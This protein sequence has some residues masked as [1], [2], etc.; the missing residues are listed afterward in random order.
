MEGLSEATVDGIC[1]LC[2]HKR[3]EG[4]TSGLQKFNT[5]N[6]RWF[7][8]DDIGRNSVLDITLKEGEHAISRNTHMRENIIMEY[9]ALSMTSME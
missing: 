3:E 8:K 6:R 5:L 7:V 4:S 2:L 1:E 9:G